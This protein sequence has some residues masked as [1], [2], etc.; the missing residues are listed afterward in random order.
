MRIA[1]ITVGVSQSGVAAH[2]GAEVDV[3]AHRVAEVR[4]SVS[5]GRGDQITRHKGRG[6]RELH[7]RAG[8]RGP[9]QAVS[10]RV[11]A[12]GHPVGRGPATNAPV[13]TRRAP[14]REDPRAGI[15][16]GGA[17]RRWGVPLRL[18]HGVSRL[19]RRSPS[20]GGESAL[21]SPVAGGLTSV[22][23]AVAGGGVGQRLASKAQAGTVAASGSTPSQVV[24]ACSAHRA[25]RATSSAYPKRNLPITVMTGGVRERASGLGVARDLAAGGLALRLGVGPARLHCPAVRERRDVRADCRRP[26]D[27][28]LV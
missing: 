24:T 14:Q 16:A 5:V 27:P 3:L 28:C 18:Q 4:R 8:S 26:D 10:D 19:R 21:G 20:V 2:R 11:L 7:P 6:A 9:G 1:A 22:S 15:T 13:P 25:H 12:E 17:A 23:P